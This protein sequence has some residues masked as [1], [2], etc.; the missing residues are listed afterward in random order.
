MLS[1][2]PVIVETAIEAQHIEQICSGNMKGVIAKLDRG[3]IDEGLRGVVSGTK[4]RSPAHTR[5]EM[6]FHRDF[7]G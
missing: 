4:T 2:S 5:V 7:G 6:R 3:F 1:R